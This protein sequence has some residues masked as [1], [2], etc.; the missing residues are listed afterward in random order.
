[1]IFWLIQ[2]L[3]IYRIAAY[4][5][6]ELRPRLVSLCH[7]DI[8][9]WEAYVWPL[10]S[11]QRTAALALFK[12]ESR[13]NPSITRNVDGVYVSM[14]LGG[15]TPLILAVIAIANYQHKG[16]KQANH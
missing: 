5:A 10:T 6:L 9:G 11:S 13:S 1:L 7:S 4:V 15:A 16:D 12:S 2:T 3:Q 8:L 14:L